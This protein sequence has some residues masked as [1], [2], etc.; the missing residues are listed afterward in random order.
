[1]PNALSLPEGGIGQKLRFSDDAAKYIF[2]QAICAQ[3]IFAG[4]GRL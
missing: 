1:M 4:D 3:R 2:S